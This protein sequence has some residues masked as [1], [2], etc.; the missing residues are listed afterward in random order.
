MPR[1]I[2]NTITSRNVAPDLLF[3]IDMYARTS[4]TREAALLPQ[5]GEHV[6]SEKSQVEQS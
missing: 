5:E 1:Q 6:T 4:G 2:E 3:S